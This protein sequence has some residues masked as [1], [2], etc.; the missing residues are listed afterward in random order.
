MDFPYTPVFPIKLIQKLC[1]YFLL[2]FPLYV[3]NLPFES[4]KVKGWTIRNLLFFFTL[5]L[6][7]LLFLLLLWLLLRL[8]LDFFNLNFTFLFRKFH[9]QGLFSTEDHFADFWS[10]RW[11]TSGIRK[12]SYHVFILLSQ[13]LCHNKSKNY[14]KLN[15]ETNIKYCQRV[16]HKERPF[17][18]AVIKS[19]EHPT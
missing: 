15:T 18:Q 16:S 5:L 6:L 14:I 7:W 19:F 1:N 12:P 3:H 13:L 2:F 17:S 10:N 11:Q 4:L 8:S 9:F